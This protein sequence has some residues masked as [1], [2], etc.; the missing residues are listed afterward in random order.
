[1]KPDFTFTNT[2]TYLAGAVDAFRFERYNYGM[3]CYL[4]APHDMPSSLKQTVVAA[5][6][7]A[8]YVVAAIVCD[9]LGHRYEDSGSYAGP[10]GAADDFTCSR[11]GHGFHHTYF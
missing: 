8:R 11:C 2:R 3:D 4:D 7:V 9:L 5:R 10:E 1:M 6:R